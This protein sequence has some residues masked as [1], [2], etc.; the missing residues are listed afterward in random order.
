MLFA[1]AVHKSAIVEK[2]K[3]I[4]EADDTIVEITMTGLH[5]HATQGFLAASPD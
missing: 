4:K 5:I 3:S 1:L 2:Y